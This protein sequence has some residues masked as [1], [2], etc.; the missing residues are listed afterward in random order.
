MNAN[1]DKEAAGLEEAKRVM[2]RLVKMPHKLHRDE[3]PHTRKAK[4]TKPS[5]EERLAL[6]ACK[7]K[8]G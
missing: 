2:E 8:S 1:K 6:A 7:P 4:Q 3:L 5:T